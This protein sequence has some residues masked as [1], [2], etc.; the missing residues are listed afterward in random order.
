MVMKLY[1]CKNLWVKSGGHPCWRV[2][3]ALD[4]AGIEYEIVPG[5]WPGRGKRDEV[6]RLSGQTKYPVI[7]FEDGSVYREES[8]D[9]AAT[10]KSGRLDEKRGV[11]QPSG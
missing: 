7:Q 11:Q 1:R 2:Q 6:E 9:M 4:D 5:P 10:I 8:R 3:K